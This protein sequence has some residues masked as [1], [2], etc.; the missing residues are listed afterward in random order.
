MKSN[1]IFHNFSFVFQ[2][3]FN[4]KMVCSIEKGIIKRQ[5]PFASVKNCHDGTGT[6]FSISFRGR[7]DYE[8][9]ATSMQE[10][11]K[12]RT[13]TCM[14]MLGYYLNH[15]STGTVIV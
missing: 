4:T 3:D 1:Q 6:R 5:L 2:V 9:E 11:Q 7:H 8:L 12:V 15:Y 10:K 14:T 13:L